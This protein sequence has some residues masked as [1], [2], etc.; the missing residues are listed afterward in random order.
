[1]RTQIALDDESH[2]QAKRK[3]ARLGITLAEYI[4]R[5]V[6]QDLAGVEPQASPSIIIGIGRSGGSDIAHQPRR[7]V[8]DAVIE[9]AGRV[10]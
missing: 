2:A 8:A 7:A 5:L 1:M 4:R 6:D 9:R 3:A 10:R